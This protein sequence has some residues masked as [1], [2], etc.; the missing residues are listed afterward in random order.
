MKKAWI[1]YSW[2]RILLNS[3]FMESSLVQCG[4]RAS[5]LLKPGV[6]SY[7]G[8]CRTEKEGEAHKPGKKKGVNEKRERG[9]G[10]GGKRGRE[11]GRKR[12][13]ERG[14]EG[15]TNHPNNQDAL[16]PVYV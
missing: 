2:L 10:G 5:P 8:A 12:R 1:N 4:P 11:A 7:K 6:M 14:M 9:K 3:A 13:G 15:E 16:L